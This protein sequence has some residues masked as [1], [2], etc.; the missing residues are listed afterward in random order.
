MALLKVNLLAGLLAAGA[1]WLIDGPILSALLAT[2]SILLVLI[3]YNTATDFVLKRL[4]AIPLTEASARTTVHRL[5]LGDAYKLGEMAGL[6]RTRFSII[7]A[8]LPMAFSMG[9]AGSGGRVIV[10]TGL[11][12]TLSRLEIAA[13][14]GHELGHIKAG[15]R[16]LTAMHLGLS[17]LLAATGLRVVLRVLSFG[18]ICGDV[19]S[20]LS[21]ISRQILRPD[22]RADAFAAQLCKDSAIMSSALQKLERGVR[23]SSW[24]ALEGIPMIARLATVNPMHALYGSDHPEKSP[25]AH[26]VAELNR[27]SFS[28]AA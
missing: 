5:F 20:S 3:W 19:G 15:E 21:R 11:F 14:T 12:K 6:P 9:S 23:S 24:S 27:L 8:P 16:S 13:V 4:R 10:T 17:L 25:M 18:L 2:L 28:K 22:C 7:D 1:G 26:R